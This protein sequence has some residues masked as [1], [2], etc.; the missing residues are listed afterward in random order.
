[1]KAGKG[2]PPTTSLDKLSST[3]EADRPNAI[4]FPI[5]PVACRYV[6]S[7]SPYPHRQTVLRR[8]INETFDPTRIDTELRSEKELWEI[9]KMRYKLLSPNSFPNDQNFQNAN[10]PNTPTLSFPRRINS[11]KLVPS[12]YYINFR[13]SSL[14]RRQWERKKEPVAGTTLLQ[15]IHERAYTG[16][17]WGQAVHPLDT[18]DIGQSRH[19]FAGGALFRKRQTGLSSFRLL[20]DCAGVGRPRLD[21]KR[22]GPPGPSGGETIATVTFS[23]ESS[24]P[25]DI[26]R[27][28]LDSLCS[29]HAPVREILRRDC[30][31]T[32]TFAFRTLDS[33]RG[34]LQHYSLWP[35]NLGSLRDLA[36]F[37]NY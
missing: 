11:T 6:V 34:W 21:P 35:L 10:L 2:S 7:P 33:R 9:V 19:R 17:D 32:R 14:G 37:I 30:S 36:D 4:P 18:V 13:A 23:I 20:Y 29:V 8:R 1:M 28:M 22:G 15:R 3:E 5:F 16:W 24:L 26:E 31:S 12:S 27:A 25:V